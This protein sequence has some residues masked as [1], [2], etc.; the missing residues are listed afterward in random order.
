MHVEVK[1][2]ITDASSKLM[3]EEQYIFFL[4]V[5]FSVKEPPQLIAC[6]FM[7]PL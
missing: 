2:I 3:A 4:C 7:F 6:P 5:Q 1:K